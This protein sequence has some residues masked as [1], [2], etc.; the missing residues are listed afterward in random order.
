MKLTDK[1]IIEALKA[2]KMIC[3]CGGMDKYRANTAGD[4]MVNGRNMFL[5]LNVAVLKYDF[6][7]VEPEIDWN[8]VIKK[9][10]LCKFWDSEVE[11]DNRRC[12]IGILKTA[13]P[14]RQRA[15]FCCSDFGWWRCCRPLRADEVNL[16][17]DEKELWK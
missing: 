11:P 16:V 10:Y 3:L 6:E 5:P 2:G 12:R 14:N 9:M 8:E 1:E 17:T 4:I 7:I 15:A 13:H